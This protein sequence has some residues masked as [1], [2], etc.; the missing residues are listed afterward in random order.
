MMVQFVLQGILPSL[1]SVMAS[2]DITIGCVLKFY[3]GDYNRLFPDV[4][5]SPHGP[6]WCACFG[7]DFLLKDY[8]NSSSLFTLQRVI[9]FYG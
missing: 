4:S 7:F 6:T 5:S 2:L 1:C 8:A 9:S 3:N